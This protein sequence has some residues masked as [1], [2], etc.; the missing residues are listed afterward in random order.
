MNPG[1][2]DDPQKDPQPDLGT[3]G[4]ASAHR[5]NETKAISGVLVDPN[6]SSESESNSPFQQ[7]WKV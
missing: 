4:L 3:T 1:Y 2:R 6:A 7:S 5:R